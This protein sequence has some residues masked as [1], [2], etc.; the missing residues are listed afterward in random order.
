MDK[1]ILEAKREVL[2]VYYNKILLL[3][4]FLTEKYGK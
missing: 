2:V 4:I 1:I 3:T